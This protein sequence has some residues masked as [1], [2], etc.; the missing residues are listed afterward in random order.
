MPPLRME[1]K[2]R[3]NIILRKMEEMGIGTVAELCRRTGLFQSTVGELVNMKELPLNVDGSWRLV[4]TR[5][6]DFFACLP[7]DLFS[8]EQLEMKLETNRAFAE[9]TFGEV[10]AL[11]ET[12]EAKCLLPDKMAEQSELKALVGKALGS[13]SPRYALI[14]RMRFG[15]NVDEYTCEEVARRLKISASRVRQI[16][17]RAL[18]ILGLR[19]DTGLLLKQFI[20]NDADVDSA[21]GDAGGLYVCHGKR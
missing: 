7:E 20:G 9:T 15:I 13:L 4:A 10:Q 14:V 3:N 5:L 17:G 6:A 16:E 2:F 8:E 21:N 1:V 11:M 12:S 18:R 19:P